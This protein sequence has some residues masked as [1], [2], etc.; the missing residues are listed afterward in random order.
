MTAEGII[1]GRIYKR[2][3]RC[4]HCRKPCVANQTNEAGKPAHLSCQ[5]K[6]QTSALSEPAG[7]TL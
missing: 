7:E 4:I 2:Y 1:A 6:V 3:R 5:E